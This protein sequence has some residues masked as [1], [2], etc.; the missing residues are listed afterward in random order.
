L[1]LCLN[2]TK[3]NPNGKKVWCTKATFY[4]GDIQLDAILSHPWLA[5]ERLGVFPHLEGLAKLNE[6][7]SDPLTIL[8]SW[9]RKWDASQL[10]GSAHVR[11]GVVTDEN[12]SKLQKKSTLTKTGLKCKK[13]RTCTKIRRGM[14]AYP[15]AHSGGY[16]KS[17]LWI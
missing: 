13:N 15:L 14:K 17:G 7:D 6:G 8:S 3:E 16:T 5:Q 11:Q 4:E 2:S 1:R 10:L 9:G 12:G